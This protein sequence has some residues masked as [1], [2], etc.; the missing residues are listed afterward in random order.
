[1]LLRGKAPGIALD[2]GKV[3]HVHNNAIRARRGDALF[4]R[5]HRR[6]RFRAILIE[7]ETGFHSIAA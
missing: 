4:E 5:V 6:H 7:V 1:M 2:L 3:G